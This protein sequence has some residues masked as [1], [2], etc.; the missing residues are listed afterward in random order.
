[1]RT[2]IAA[3]AAAFLFAAPARVAASSFTLSSFD[4]AYHKTDPGLVLWAN[5][6]VDELTFSL[7]AVGQTYSK[8]LFE[9]GTDEKALNL[10]DLIPFSIAVNFL[11]TEPKPD[12]GGQSKG[13]TG[14]G[15]WRNSFGYV[16]WDN[17]LILEFGQT[18]LLGVTLS[19]VTFG[20]P[21]SANVMANF[22]L[23]RADAGVTSV[24][25]PG[26]LSLL[27]VGVAAAAIARRK[28]NRRSAGR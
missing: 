12:F 8:N 6:L 10:D 19:H 27:G 28:R 9:I 14:A 21:G 25:E 20:L 15:W 4:V 2:T 1:M 11:F 22:E 3:I 18:G 7:D 23:V 17:P 5:P 24:P 13:I 16:L 26:T